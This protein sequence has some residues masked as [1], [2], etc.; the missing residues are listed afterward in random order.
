MSDEKVIKAVCFEAEDLPTTCWPIVVSDEEGNV[1]IENLSDLLARQQIARDTDGSV[2]Y[3]PPSE[4]L[5]IVNS[6]DFQPKDRKH[7]DYCKHCG[8]PFSEH[9]G[10][11]PTCAQHIE[12]Q[13]KLNKIYTLAQAFLDEEWYSLTYRISAHEMC[14]EIMELKD[15]RVSDA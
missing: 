13:S 12:A 14:K 5:I 10:V 1:T 7:L 11:T 9:L 6:Q 8:I 3:T 15:K 4:D 2:K